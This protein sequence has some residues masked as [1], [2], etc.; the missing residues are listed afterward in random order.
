MSGNI[1]KRRF[2]ENP[3]LRVICA[4]VLCG[5][6]ICFAVKFC[7]TSCGIS[8]GIIYIA[9]CCVM[10][11]LLVLSRGTKKIKRSVFIRSA[12]AA[13]TL[14]P[15]FSFWAFIFLF[16]FDFFYGLFFSRLPEAEY[17]LA[18]SFMLSAVLMACGIK[19]ATSLGTTEVSLVSDKLPKGKVIKVLHLTDLHL[20]RYNSSRLLE[21]SVEIAK[22]TQPDIIAVTGDVA[23]GEIE[24]TQKIVTHYEKRY[25]ADKLVEDVANKAAEFAERCGADGKSVHDRAE[26]FEREFAKHDSTDA[27]RERD[28]ALFRAMPHKCGMF[29]VTGNHDYYDNIDNAVDFMRRAGMTVLDNEFVE[30]CGIVVAGVS[31]S[32]HIDRAKWGLSKS[33]TVLVNARSAYPDKF[34]L[35]LRH[36]P[37]LEYGAHRLFDLQLSGHT[38]GG[39]LFPLFT[40][41]LFFRS[42]PRGLKKLKDGSMLCVSNGIGYVGPPVRL[43]APPEVVI[44][45]VT[46]NGDVDNASIEA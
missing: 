36:R 12:D 41:R 1:Y 30:D 9:V 22:K 46:G 35:L 15:L 29:A 28:A 23:D 43:F 6:Y 34:I 38:H 10:T 40:S 33:E 26:D 42:L 27:A 8:A 45:T 21:M 20:S 17:S 2:S 3:F 13:G 24:C 39:Q 5:I 25:L 31:D 7:R 44:I 16:A 32:A 11:F 14:Y 18:F 4:A 37:V 19:Q